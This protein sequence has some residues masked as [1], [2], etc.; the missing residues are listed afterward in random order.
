MQ[1]EGE[2]KFFIDIFIHL[3][4]NNMDIILAQQNFEILYI[5]LD[6]TKICPIS[7]NLFELNKAFF[8]KLNFSN[9]KNY[10]NINIFFIRNFP[11][12]LNKIK[13]II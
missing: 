9:L 6:L 13:N 3:S 11:F 4:E 1:E 8:I 7:S 12:C 2:I 10:C 5:I